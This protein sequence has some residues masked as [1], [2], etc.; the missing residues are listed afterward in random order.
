MSIDYQKELV[1][2]PKSNSKDLLKQLETW[3]KEKGYLA[4]DGTVKAKLTDQ[5]CVKFMDDLQAEVCLSSKKCI[6][7]ARKST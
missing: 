1:T 6:K 3:A 7:G 2:D 4:E 5:Q